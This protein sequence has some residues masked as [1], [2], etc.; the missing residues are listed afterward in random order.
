LHNDLSFPIGM[1]CLVTEF[2]PLQANPY[3]LDYELSRLSA[4]N[5]FDI[6]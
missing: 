5:V 4:Q 1:L 2:F 6:C 3:F